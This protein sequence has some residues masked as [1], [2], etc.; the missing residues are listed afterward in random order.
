MPDTIPALPY[1]QDITNCFADKIGKGGLDRPTFDDYVARTAKALK[2]LR[3]AVSDNSLPILTL[4]K[5]EDEMRVMR[6]AAERYRDLEHVIVMGTGG[7][8]LG[9]KTVT[10]LADGG[11]GSAGRLPGRPLLWFIENVDPWGF[12]KTVESVDPKSTGL[13]IISKSGGTAETLS[14]ALALLPRTFAASSPAMSV[15]SM[16]I[17]RAHV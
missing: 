6:E 10:A 4:P 14:Q 3:A 11:L 12:E 15:G 8:S 9:G 1:S 7:S 16:Q 17:G 5:R 13:I 2:R